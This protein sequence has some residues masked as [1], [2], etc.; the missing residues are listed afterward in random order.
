M[1][2]SYLL[3]FLR[4]IAI[5][6]HNLIPLNSQAR[7]QLQRL[8]QQHLRRT[9]ATAKPRDRETAIAI[10]HQQLSADCQPDTIQCNYNNIQPKYDNTE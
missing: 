8:Q 1:G 4:S 6:H 2:T 10:Q 7:V 3:Y 5:H 9:P